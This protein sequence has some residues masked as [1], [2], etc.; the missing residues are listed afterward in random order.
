MISRRIFL[1]SFQ[2]FLDRWSNFNILS[3]TLKTI[4]RLNRYRCIVVFER[5]RGVD[6]SKQMDN[7]Q[8]SVKE[9]D[10]VYFSSSAYFPELKRVLDDL[11]ISVEDS[12]LDYGS[13][14]GATLVL[15]RKYRF[16]MVAG[17]EL[18]KK[19]LLIADRNFQKLKIKDL[20]LFQADAR[21]F[22]DIDAYNYFYFYNPF[23]CEIM[24]VVLQNIIDS[25]EKSPRS[26]KLIYCNPSC[27]ELIVNC[28][29]FSQLKRYEGEVD[30][31]T[32]IVYQSISEGAY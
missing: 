29:Y 19:L 9:S 18:S 24:A 27:H 23:P 15:F 16:K 5:L 32:I 7:K 28:G 21:Q 2:N 20:R 30:W 31:G 26:V 25:I 3:M 14:K 10:G 1:C 8:T 11:H 4:L 13:G 12:I 22:K 6:F 17:V